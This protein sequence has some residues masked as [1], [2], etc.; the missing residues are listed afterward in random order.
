MKNDM[1]M[2][3]SKGVLGATFI[4]VT[5]QLPPIGGEE[6]YKLILQTIIGLWTTLS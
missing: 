3:T 5:E 6:L 2:E 4:E 1:I